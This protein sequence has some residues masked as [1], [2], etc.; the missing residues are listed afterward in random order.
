M[1]PV[2]ELVQAALL[3]DQLVPWAQEQVERVAQDHLVAK[4]AHLASLKR[5]DGRVRGE[6]HE[7]R[8]L[9]V[10][11]RQMQNARAGRACAGA[12]LE[13]RRDAAQT[14]RLRLGRAALDRGGLCVAVALPNHLDAAGL[15]VRGPRYHDLEHAVVE[16]GRAL[17]RV[18]ALGQ[19]QLAAELPVRAL[20]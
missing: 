12:Y 1:W 20:E 15:P 10:T 4:V 5:A 16:G 19:R 7:G 3:G 8:R 9:H 6:R 14:R 11:M 17:V 18:D 2:H 13:E